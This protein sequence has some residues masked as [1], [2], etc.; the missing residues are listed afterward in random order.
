M[1]SAFWHYVLA[2]GICCS[3]AVSAG[4]AQS[5]QSTAP[6][7][8]ANPA[9]ALKA[10]T[11]P[12]HPTTSRPTGAACAVAGT[13]SH[14][15]PALA[16]QFEYVPMPTR[17]S[18]RIITGGRDRT[19]IRQTQIPAQPT[20][21]IQI[22]KLAPPPEPEPEPKISPR[23]WVVPAAAHVSPTTGNLLADGFLQY[24]RGPAYIA[25]RIG[26]AIWNVRDKTVRMTAD[27]DRSIRFQVVTELQGQHRRLVLKTDDLTGPRPLP[28]NRCVH[29]SRVWYTRGRHGREP[30]SWWDSP[31]T[32]VP[33]VRPLLVPSEDNPVSGQ[34][35]QAFVVSIYIPKLVLPGMYKTTLH[36]TDLND[37]TYGEDIPIEP[38]RTAVA[39]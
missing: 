24:D 39:D 5:T 18:R 26:N 3:M 19:T 10:R 23:I 17:G 8:H 14:A 33:I 37:L 35:N 29:I 13:V 25:Y 7:A 34:T 22:E 31:L 6:S 12:V 21:T 20:V 4:W 11:S 28:A 9:A 1:Q 2:N 38:R 15:V 16:G 32:L 27:K 30:D 36:I